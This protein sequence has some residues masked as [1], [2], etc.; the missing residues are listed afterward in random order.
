MFI[1]IFH[2]FQWKIGSGIIHGEDHA[3]HFQLRIQF[4]LY[5]IHSL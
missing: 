1:Y 3:F 4:F 5:Q 2:Y